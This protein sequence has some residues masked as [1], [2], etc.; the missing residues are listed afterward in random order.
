MLPLRMPKAGLSMEE[1]SISRWLKQEGD[2]LEKGEVVLEI[3]TDKVTLEVEA[4]S[5]GYLAK[6]VAHEGDT[7]RVNETIAWIAQKEEELT[8]DSVASEQSSES[9][10][11]AQPQEQVISKGYPFKSEQ[12]KE[13]FIKASPSARRLARQHNV[14]LSQLTGTG[15]GGRIVQEDI[16][17]Y[18]KSIQSEEPIQNAE[19]EEAITKHNASPLSDTDQAIA[20]LSG[21]RKVI[22]KRMS[23]SAQTIPHVTLTTRVDVSELKAFRERIR[24]AAT[25]TPL[26]DVT[27][28]HIMIRIVSR[29]LQ[30]NPQVNVSLN[31]DGLVYHKDV[32]MGI[33]VDAPK[34]LVV[35]VLKHADTLSLQDIVI[36]TK[37][38]VARARDNLLKPNEISGGTFTISNLGTYEIDEFTPIINPPEAA[39]LGVGRILEMPWVNNG[40]VEPRPIMTLSLSFDH[41]VLDGGPAAKFLR[42]IKRFIESPY[43]MV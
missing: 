34:G 20:S 23:Y 24:S 19:R 31:D 9:T 4:P 32:H 12:R 37:D 2:S 27:Y 36:T 15:P 14:D 18:V 38:L 33:A 17:N 39:I 42:T 41:R 3:E 1:G 10:Q 6:I 29:A 25:D 26:K 5:D 7:V 40:V 11:N 22:A 21:V 28:T 13:P 35:P 16:L 43:L 30:Q 8:V